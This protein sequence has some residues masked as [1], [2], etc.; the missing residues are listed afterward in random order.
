MIPQ[1]RK[2]LYATDLSKNSAYAFFYAVDMAKKYNAN[3]VILHT[4]EPIPHVY[5][6]GGTSVLRSIEKKQQA[7]DVEDIKKRIQKFCK[8]IENQ[9]SFPC[10]DL[11]SNILVPLG[12]PVEEI[13]KAV[14]DEGCDVI[15]LGTHGK[16]F[17]RQTFLGSVSVSVLER[18][19]K[20]VY[21]IP[22]P[23]EKTNIDWDNI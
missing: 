2:I 13:L 20:P 16:G 6:E 9:N 12:Y 5:A 10:I 7:S 22:L 14:D 19:R 3:I 1:I 15:I 4:V 8:I 23:T 21:I 17:L 18:T 11:V